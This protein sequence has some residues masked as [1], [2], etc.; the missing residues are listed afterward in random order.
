MSLRSTVGSFPSIDLSPVDL[1]RLGQLDPRQF[2]IAGLSGERVLAV[3]R[4]AAYVG[5]G[6]GVLT[7][8]QLQVRRRELT[9]RLADSP[10]ARQLGLTKEQTDDIVDRFATSRSTL[11]AALDRLEAGYDARVDAAMTRVEPHLPPAAAA[12]LEQAHGV[13]KLARQQVRGLL[14]SVA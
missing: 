2:E 1:S 6:A 3:L 4:D 14:R 5:V 11:D 9:A 10:V 8:Q 12:A 7:F 13:A